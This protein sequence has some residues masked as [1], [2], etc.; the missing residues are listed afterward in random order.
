MISLSLP[1]PDEQS[2]QVVDRLVDLY[3]ALRDRNKEHKNA[4]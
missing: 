4:E 2:R 3:C 1:A